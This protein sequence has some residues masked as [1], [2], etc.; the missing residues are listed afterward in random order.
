MVRGG[1]HRAAVLGHLGFEK[2]PVTIKRGWDPF[3][4]RQAA[5]AW[6]MVASRQISVSGARMIFDQYFVEGGLYSG[7]IGTP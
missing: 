5:E 1:K 2:I 6:P 7:E 4:D 3:I